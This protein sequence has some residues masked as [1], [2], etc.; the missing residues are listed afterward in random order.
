LPRSSW[1]ESLDPS[2]RK[3]LQGIFRSYDLVG[4]IVVTRI[5]PQ[6]EGVRREIGELLLEQNPKARLVLQA[7]G[8]TKSGAR[9]RIMRTI[10]GEGTSLTEHREHGTT[11][12]VDV[13]R[14]CF[15]PRL[16]H[17]RLRVAEQVVDGERVLNMF[18][19]AGSFSLLIARMVES[20]VFSADTNPAAIECMKRGIHRNRFA[21]TV[22]PIFGNSK[23]VF[24]RVPKFDRIILPLPA[25]SDEFL[26]L[27][28]RLSVPGGVIHHYREV[29]G[30]RGDCL[31][32]SLTELDEAM[33]QSAVRDY[34]VLCSRVIRSVGRKRWHVVHDIRFP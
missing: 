4:D 31:G 13:S 33:N 6:L 22:L 14:V 23:L 12:I 29:R 28:S 7:H 21:G 5:P 17:E 24:K 32:K 2:S 26:D 8:P 18:S 27:A 11:Y 25:I 34:D 10:A 16:S 3:A 1:L 30:L 9:T 19:G 20:V 15:T